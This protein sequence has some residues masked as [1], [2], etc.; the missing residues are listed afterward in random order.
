MKRPTGDYIICCTYHHIRNEINVVVKKCKY[1]NIQKMLNHL[2]TK[3][4]FNDLGRA[5]QYCINQPHFKPFFFLLTTLKSWFVN[6][7]NETVFVSSPK[8]LRINLGKRLINKCICFTRQCV[9]GRIANTNLW[10]II[11]LECFCKE[12]VYFFSI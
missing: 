9:L 7:Q 3:F 10:M 2:S 11:S 8:H 5:R 6:T 1:V 4:C 12:N